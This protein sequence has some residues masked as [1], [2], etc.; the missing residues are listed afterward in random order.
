MQPSKELADEL[1]MDKVRAAR[2]MNPAE[3]FLDG[4]RL[5]DYACRTVEWGIRNQH[6]EASESDVRRLLCERVDLMRKLERSA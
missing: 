1:F 2:S 3:K 5:F 4:L 6:P